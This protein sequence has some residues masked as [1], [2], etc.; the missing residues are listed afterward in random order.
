MKAKEFLDKI[1][2][3]SA[4]VKVKV[5]GSSTQ[6]KTVVFAD[7]Q[8]QARALLQAAY[9]DKSVISVDKLN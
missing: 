3:Y 1:N 4:T 7:T 2:K 6:V 5:N 9:G 8:T